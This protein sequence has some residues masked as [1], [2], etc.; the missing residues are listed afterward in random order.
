MS[1]DRP[2]PTPARATLDTM[3]KARSIAIVGASSDAARI[4][5]IPVVL[6]KKH[7]TGR[8]IPVNPNRDE[9]A[10]LATIP[11]VAH[12]AGG[13]DLAIIALPAHAAE[14]A[15]A[16]CVANGVGSIVLFSAGF[17]EIDEAGM[18]A[19]RR[20]AARCAERGVR[21]IGPNSLGFIN[22]HSG[23]YATFS[24]ALDNVWPEKGSI[25]IASQSGAAGSYIMALAAE[26][27]LGLS[28]FIA[29]GNEADVDVADCVDWMAGDPAT[30]II[31]VYLESCRDGARLRAA[32]AA[33]RRARKPVIAIKPGS[34]EVGLAAAKS[35]TGNLAGS[36]QAFD[37]VLTS[38]GAWIAQSLEEAV[39]IAQ[40]CV[41]RRFPASGE[42]LVVTPSG[43][44]GIM[45]ADAA[46]E[47]G[48]SLPPLPDEAAAAI[49]RLLPLAS[50]T[51]P[52]DTTAQVANDFRL[53]GQVIGI[54]AERTGIPIHLVFMAHMGK[55]PAVT[56][57][58]CPTLKAVAS[59]WPD[60]VFALITRA[61]PAFAAEMRAAGLLVF[62]DPARAVRAVAALRAFAQSFARAETQA[63]ALRRLPQE[64]LAEAAASGEGAVRLLDAIGIPPLRAA[65]AATL[66]EAI[67]I[68]R[69][70]GFPIAL[71][72]DSPDI[73]HKTEVGGVHLGIA[74]EATLARAWA[75]MM[76]TV[77]ERA[78]AARISGALISP[79]IAQGVETIIGTQNDP[80]FGPM[81]L[82][83]LGGT[84]VEALKDVVLAP[85][86]VD[87]A[88]ATAMLSSI[89]A[90][91]LLEGW[92]GAA[93]VD[94]AA[95]ARAV[96]ALSV[97][98][99]SHPDEVE[100]IEVNPFVAMPDGGFAI[101]ALLQLRHRD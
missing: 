1:P 22:F 9:I 60:R 38:E 86:P 48:L 101:D 95:L 47:A 53:F 64:M 34:T 68:A 43:G 37:A 97:F 20:M 65:P 62:Q 40:A 89:R 51:N 21:L 87:H 69:E 13:C 36:K 70:I 32:L 15:V 78:P 45:L 5:G 56:D 80:V 72:I 77:R 46:D 99:A 7:F 3:I 66:D 11:D 73:Q 71:K 2:Y 8:V 55:T 75:S 30:E 23:L 81:V 4:G 57:L 28:H 63:P 67:T 12:L 27:G 24:S 85:A 50:V 52:V 100:S 93:P 92:R 6:N 59:A 91:A 10:G 18:A 39:D 74:D 42:A 41:A 33:A 49:K 61:S 54:A 96:V 35:H 14:A 98:A 90:K 58:L 31:V 82:F 26:A 19:Q 84:A 17:G 29:T 16:D 83:G 88:G 25:G 79:M 94:R 76:S 44:V